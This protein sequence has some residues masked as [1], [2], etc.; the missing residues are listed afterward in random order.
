MSTN[1]EYDRRSRA[2][3]SMAGLRDRGCDLGVIEDLID[4]ISGDCDHRA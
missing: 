4:S 1:A 3:K 2:G